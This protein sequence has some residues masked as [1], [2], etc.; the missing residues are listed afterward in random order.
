MTPMSLESAIAST[1]AYIW[2]QAHHHSRIWNVPA[3]DLYQEGAIGVVIAHEKFKPG[4]ASFLTYASWWIY[5]KMRMF[6]VNNRSVVRPPHTRFAKGLA[7]HPITVSIDA[8]LFDHSPETFSDTLPDP[9]PPVSND[10]SV[11]SLIHSLLAELPARQRR[12]IT[13]HYFEGLSRKQIAYELGLS[14]ERIRQILI[15]TRLV[16]RRKLAER[17][18]LS[19]IGY[20]T[21]PRREP[22]AISAIGY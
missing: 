11:S 22:S 13:A 14:Q 2:Q 10:P 5:A 3:E 16:L 18:A 1:S 12:V 20:R 9:N 6:C 4:R 17:S 19:A 21:Q 15:T 7:A 8:P